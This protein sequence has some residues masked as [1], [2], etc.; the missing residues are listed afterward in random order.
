MDQFNAGKP[1]N[2]ANNAKIEGGHYIPGVGRDAKGNFVV[3]T[4][5]KIQLM[6]ARFYKK[7]CDE[8]V[9]YVPDEALLAG[10]KT[11]DGFNLA[12]LQADLNALPKA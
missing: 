10:G 2:V 5:G 4:W 11:L 3:V 7:Y 12:E 1:W 9:A 6:T 8:V